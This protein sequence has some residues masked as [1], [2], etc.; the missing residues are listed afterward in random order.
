MHG[1]QLGEEDALAA[2]PLQAVLDIAA[3]GVAMMARVGADAVAGLF[4]GRSVPEL[5]EADRDVAFL[6]AGPAIADLEAR[7]EEDGM[8]AAIVGPIEIA[9]CQEAFPIGLSVAHDAIAAVNV[10]FVEV[11][12]IEEG[13]GAARQ[14][15][16]GI[17]VEAK[18]VL[19]KMLQAAFDH[20]A[21]VE[22]VAVACVF[23]AGDAGKVMAAAD[24]AG[25]PIVGVGDD[26]PPVE[27]G[28]V[29]GGGN[30][31][32]AGI[33]DADGDGFEAH[34]SLPGI[35]RRGFEAAERAF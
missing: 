17:D 33:V 20:A 2:V 29:E 22:G 28:G 11:G 5:E 4:V 27:T 25:E 3:A 26:D 9:G 31:E 34:R 6:G 32:L 15:D 13:A 30:G 23:C 19:G 21:L 24:L 16:V 7:R 14:D 8:R 12:P 18:A 1:D 35:N 10:G